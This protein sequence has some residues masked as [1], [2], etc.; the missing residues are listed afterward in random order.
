MAR[1][2]HPDGETE[3]LIQWMVDSDQWICSQG[4]AQVK[5]VCKKCRRHEYFHLVVQQVPAEERKKEI[6]NRECCGGENVG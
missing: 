5:G 2:P 4:D 3:K 6:M 1:L